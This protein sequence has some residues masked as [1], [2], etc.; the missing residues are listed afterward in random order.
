MIITGE[1]C[2]LTGKQER[3]KYKKR[4][5]EYVA[6]V[7]VVEVEKVRRRRSKKKMR[8]WHLLVSRRRPVEMKPREIR[9]MILF[10]SN[11]ETSFSYQNF[12]GF[13]RGGE[14]PRLCSPTWTI[15]K[16]GRK[17]KKNGWQGEDEGQDRV[18]VCVCV[19]VLMYLVLVLLSA[20]DTPVKTE[21]GHRHTV[22]SFV[23]SSADIEVSGRSRDDST[24]GGGLAAPL[25]SGRFLK[26]AK[27][28]KPKKKKVP[29]FFGFFPRVKI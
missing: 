23:R 27:I 21:A 26:L 20:W 6:A 29:E 12:A 11:D 14:T 7:P 13:S 25:P 2:L 22:R 18:C 15:F 1:R 24:Q 17:R 5:P 3:G 9:N 8:Q 19:W 16:S 10:C 4:A 28:K